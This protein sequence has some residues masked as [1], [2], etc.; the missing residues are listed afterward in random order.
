MTGKGKKNEEFSLEIVKLERKSVS[1]TE[2]DIPEG[3]MLQ[4]MGSMPGR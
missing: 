4:D 2:F 3:Y 1:D